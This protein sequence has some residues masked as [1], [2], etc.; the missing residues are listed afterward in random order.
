[1]ANKGVQKSDSHLKRQK[2]VGKEQKHKWY[3]RVPNNPMHSKRYDHKKTQK[4]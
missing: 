3:G 1:M 2:I 4:K